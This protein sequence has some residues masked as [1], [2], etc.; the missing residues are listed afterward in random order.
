MDGHVQELAGILEGDLLVVV[1]T[2]GVANSPK[3]AQVDFVICRTTETRVFKI[4]VHAQERAVPQQRLVVRL[5]VCRF[6]LEAP[7]AA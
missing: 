6:A 7:H 5:P 1:A 2:H 3:A 4:L